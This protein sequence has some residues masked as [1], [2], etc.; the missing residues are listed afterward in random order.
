MKN[1]KISMQMP[2][3]LLIILSGIMLTGCDSTRLWE[4]AE[5]ENIADF[6]SSRGDTVFEAKPSG[7]YYYSVLEGTGIAPDDK[8]TASIW[9]SSYF[10]DYYPFSTNINQPSP[11]EFIV[12]SGKIILDTTGY[13]IYILKGLNEAVQ[14]MKVGGIAKLVLPSSLAFGAE[15]F[16]PYVRGYEPLIYKVELVDVRPAEKK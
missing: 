2:L 10:I 12:G 9:Y 4:R 6:L 5:S 7:L 16:Y 11:L 14:Y 3:V 8:D 13:N 15:G 1:L